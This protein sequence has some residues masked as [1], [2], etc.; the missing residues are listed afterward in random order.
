MLGRGRA[1][2]H[3]VQEAE[4]AGGVG[5]QKETLHISLLL[6]IQYTCTQL[7]GTDRHQQNTDKPD[8]HQREG[9]VQN[10]DHHVGNGQVDNEEAGGGVHPFVLD[11]HMAHQDVAEERDA[12]DHRV[13]YYQQRLHCPALGLTLILGPA[14]K[15]PQV[16]Q[17]Q[18]TVEEGL[19]RE[20]IQCREEVGRV[21]IL[22]SPE[23]L[24][25]VLQREPRVPAH[26]SGSKAPALPVS[27]GRLHVPL[28]PPSGQLRC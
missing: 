27:L 14:V 11:H 26:G 15:V 7:T 5:R 28:C 10:G 21:V 2:L 6:A 12:D 16:L 24:G 1:R 17:V 13:G 18:T 8:A 23:G 20:A 3:L 19:I 9:G 4:V 25:D 22:R